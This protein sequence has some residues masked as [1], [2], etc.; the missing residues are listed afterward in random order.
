MRSKVINKCE[1]LAENR[2]I[3]GKTFK[4]EFDYMTTA[5]ASIFTSAGVLANMER[6][7][8]CEKI[9]K[10]HTSWLS[11]IRG[12]S[13]VPVIAKMALSD[14]PEEYIKKVIAI[15]DLMKSNKLAGSEYKVMAAIA[16][17]EKDI[18]EAQ[19]YILRT[20]ELYKKMSKEHW[21][22]T[23]CEDIPFAALLATSDKDIDSMISD[24]EESYKLLKN[25]YF[26]KNAVQSVTHI[27]TFSDDKPEVKCEKFNRVYDGLKANKHNIGSG[28]ELCVLGASA[29]TD[30]SAETIVDLICEADDNL[31]QKKGFGALSLGTELR[32]LLASQIVMSTCFDGSNI[33]DEITMTSML[34]SAIAVETCMI[35]CS[36]AAANAAAATA[37]T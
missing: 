10:A 36:L 19:T 2:K 6:L 30:V 28:Y 27:L 23:S 32:R 17:A 31:A 11:N 26:S 3:F 24:M 15:Y 7:K 1:L 14:N 34:A 35:I 8:E 21:I 13:E 18:E 9:L 22:L 12:F 25:K 16:L 29:L 37:S 5:G 33:A 4:W 20:A